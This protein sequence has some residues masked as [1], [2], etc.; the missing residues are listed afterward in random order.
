MTLL[1]LFDDAPRTGQIL[2]L[3]AQTLEK[4]GKGW[5]GKTTSE[6]FVTNESW[7]HVKGNSMTSVLVFSREPRLYIV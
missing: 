2:V 7:R 6:E 1:L 4:D 5:L 3:T